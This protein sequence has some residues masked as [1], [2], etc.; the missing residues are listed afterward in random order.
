MRKLLT[1]LTAVLAVILLA[2][3]GDDGISEDDVHEALAALPYEVTYEDDSYDGKFVRGSVAGHGGR[4]QFAVYDR[5]TE[6]ELVSAELLSPVNRHRNVT[7][8]ND[9]TSIAIWSPQSG[10]SGDVG[11]DVYFAICEILPEDV[12]AS[13]V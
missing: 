6:P 2:A 7:G 3:C 1:V 12:Q 8:L 10:P 13:C 11:L 5:G 9:G 4:V